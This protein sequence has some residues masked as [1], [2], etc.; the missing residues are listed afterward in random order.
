MSNN[1]SVVATWKNTVPRSFFDTKRLK[2]ECQDIY[3]KY[4]DYTGGSRMFL[5]K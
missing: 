5:I 2:K 3:S 4:I 1:G